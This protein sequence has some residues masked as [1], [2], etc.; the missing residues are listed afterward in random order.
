MF[1]NEPIFADCDRRDREHEM[2]LSRLPVCSL[3]DHPI[4]DE[5]YYVIDGEPVCQECLDENF[6]RYVNLDD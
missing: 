2:N 3:C 1:Y 4:E 5:H 6:K